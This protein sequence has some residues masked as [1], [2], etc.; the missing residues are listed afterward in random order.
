MII[1]EFVAGF[2]DEPPMNLLKAT[3]SIMRT[4]SLRFATATCGFF[5]PEGSDLLQDGM[6]VK[7]GVRPTDICGRTVKRLAG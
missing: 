5:V 7:M 3:S 1:N 2:I 4:I 6:Q